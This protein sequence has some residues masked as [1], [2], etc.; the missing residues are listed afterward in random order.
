MLIRGCWAL[1]VVSAWAQPTE[2]PSNFWGCWV[3]KKALPTAGISGLSP[4]QQKAM[5]GRRIVFAPTCAR[6][7]GTVIKSPK[8]SATVLSDRE[9]FQL[10]YVRL[11]E[12]GIQEDKVTVVKLDLHPV[13]PTAG[14]PGTP[15][16]PGHLAAADFPGVRAYLRK[17]D[18]VFE[19]E[20]DYFVAQRA[21]PN[22]AGCTCESARGHGGRDRVIW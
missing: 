8:Y 14:A 4:A 2:P 20:N 17:T 6:S 9:F 16:L 7:G 5:I 1:L 3:V 15:E 18:I 10:G 11:G 13:T 12:I 22:G 19:V 21:R